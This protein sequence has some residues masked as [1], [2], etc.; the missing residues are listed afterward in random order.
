MKRTLGLSRVLVGLVLGTAAILFAGEVRTTW[1]IIRKLKKLYPRTVLVENGRAHS[2]IVT[3]GG[4]EYAGAV[5]KL[6]SVFQREAGVRLAVKTASEI[7]DADWSIDFATIGNMNLI[8]LGNV[9]DNRLLSV[10]Y[11]ERYVV[12]DSIYPGRGGH[13]VRTVHDPFAKG[14][15]VVVLAGSDISG[16]E[17]A[18]SVFAEKF[19]R[20]LGKNI[21]LPEPIVDVEF[22]KKA[23]RFFP[24]AT[25]Y[26]TSKRQPQYTGMGWFKDRLRKAGFMDA[27]GRI[28]KNPDERTT[29]LAVTGM[30][31]RMGQT[32]FRTG[33]KNLLPLMKE[34]VD[35]NRSLLKN[36]AKLHGMGSRA[37]SHVAEWDLLEELPIWTDRDRLD[38]TNA[39]LMDASLGHERRAFHKQV[40]E[41][42][43]QTLDENHGTS[44]ALHSFNAWYYFYKYYHI[45]E[46]EY[47]IRC[48]DAVFSAQAS[49][50]QILEDASGYLCYCPDHAMAYSLKRKNLTYFKRGIAFEHAKYVSLACTNN[51]GLNTGFGDSTGLVIPRFFEVLAPAAWYYRDP[52]LYWI[53]RNW[54]PV[55]CGLRIFQKS[56]AIDLS[57]KPKEPTEWTG[58]IR[59]PLYE[60]P[61]VKGQ[62]VKTPVFAPKKDV[63]KKLFNKIVFKENWDSDG[64]YLLL[65][66]AGTWRGPPGP[67]GHKHNDIN[68]II[69]FTACGRMWLVDHTY[70]MRAFQDHSGVYAT[71]NGRG[72]YRKRTLATLNNFAESTDYGLTRSTFL[73]WQRC[74]FWKKGAYF[75]ILDKVVADKDGEYFARCSLRGLGEAR[76]QGKNMFLSQ[77]GRYC[78]IISDGEANVDMEKYE[79]A[80]KAHWGAFYEYA[81]PVAKIF[82][83]DKRRILKKG[84]SIS[85][86]NLLY[87][88]SSEDAEGLVTMQ[89]VTKTCALVFER[90]APTVLGLGAI[91]GNLGQAEMFVVS[92]DVIFVAGAE[93]APG[94]MLETD[95][96]CDIC[97]DVRRNEI[98]LN[99]REPTNVKLRGPAA[100][101]TDNGEP[102][103]LP[104]VAG[105]VSLA[106][107]PGRHVVKLEGWKGFE[108]ASGVARRALAA[109]QAKAVERQAQAAGPSKKR[110]IEGLELE[111][112]KLDAGISILRLADIDGDGEDEWVVG[113]AQGVSVYEPSGTKLWNFRTAHNVRALDVGDLDGDGLPEIAAGCDD[114]RVY[115]LNRG[116]KRKWAFACKAST[117]TI[118]RRPVVD[119]VRITDLDRDGNT[120]IVVGANWVHVLDSNGKL[121]WERYMD[122]RRGR[123]CGDFVCGTVSD[124]DGDGQEEIVALFLTS[125]P[126]LQVFDASGRIVTPTGVAPNAYGGVNI[127]VPLQVAALDLFGGQKQKQIVYAGTSR[128][129]FL[130][131]NHKKK[132]QAAGKVG[133]T[134][135]KM[136]Y[137]QPDPK[138]RTM[139]FG[140]TTLCGIVGIKPRPK[141]NDRRIVADA[142]WHRNIDEKISAIL[143]ADLN[144]DSK[145]EV[146]VGTKGGNV[147]VFDAQNGGDLGL[148]EIGGAPVSCILLAGRR[149]AVVV[150][151]SDGTVVTIYGQK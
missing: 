58:L 110:T 126:L 46:S 151:K 112:V 52:R 129:G 73:N 100:S 84:E 93:S 130:W 28:V 59:I 43:V 65:D 133:G 123:I 23:Y 11:G 37:A 147:Y 146:Y 10:L 102:L 72:G 99:L 104:R 105:A 98:S 125:Y 122:F 94:R 47:W 136:S 35:K 44:S 79:Y 138:E 50:Y 41:G 63:D 55:N 116:G 16:V 1:P 36:P 69:N 96:K 45:P 70:Q 77:K 66:G 142:V 107:E 74:I 134:F 6:Q 131:G 90:G 7:V 9:N 38:I 150:A 108:E 31:A 53:V 109:A 17:K 75:F 132:E 48:A 124:L 143:A 95:K 32:Y 68:T 27:S 144:A 33:N 135:V 18:I 118:A 62:G 78:K 140:A 97:L 106:L 2:F 20:G 3:P 141:R 61:L 25:H 71:C 34:L 8:A 149:N 51:L 86:M 81:E 56:I 13:V 137:F 26:L 85:F 148:A 39:L 87:A 82:Q 89:P 83:Q 92:A 57:V 30:I 103:A 113:G 121:R 76:L 29:L 21:T 120:E 91:P 127:D 145:G 115:L 119:Y 22:E 12:A 40:K 24:D 139:I 114:E 117:G 111:T 80:N 101:A 49:T 19:V 64:Q 54:L 14:V 5:S 88:Y 42:C 15:N 67:H 60:A 128:I 4:E